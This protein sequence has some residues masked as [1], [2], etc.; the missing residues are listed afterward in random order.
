[1]DTQELAAVILSQTA[2][3]NPIKYANI[4]RATKADE[5]GQIRELLPMMKENLDRYEK[6]A[7][8][9]KEFR[10]QVS[11]EGYAKRRKEAKK[12]FDGLDKQQDVVS[13]NSSPIDISVI[14]SSHYEH[15]VNIYSA[16]VQGSEL[17]CSSKMVSLDETLNKWSTQLNGASLELGE[18]RVKALFNSLQ[19]GSED[20]IKGLALEQQINRGAS[21]TFMQGLAILEKIPRL[22]EQ[23]LQ[24]QSRNFEHY[25]ERLRHRHSN[26]MV[27]CKYEG[28]NS[29]TLTD[30]S[31]LIWENLD[32]VGEIESGHSKDELSAYTIHRANAMI[33]AAKNDEIWKWITV[34]GSQLIRWSEISMPTVDSVLRLVIKLKQIIGEPVWKLLSVD[35]KKVHRDFIDVV[36]SLDLSQ[37]T[38]RPPERAFSKTEK[39]ALEHQNKS[40]QKVADLMA[41]GESVQ[42]IVSEVLKLK[43]I[44]RNFF[45]LENSFYVCRIGTG[46]MFTGESPGAIEII[47]GEKPHVNLNNIWGSGFDEVR[48]FISGMDEAKKWSPLFLA[49]SPSK[50]TDKANVLLVGP[51]GCGKCVRGDT[52]I[53]T[54]RG[55]KTILE[56]QPGPV[57][58]DGYHPI[59]VGVRSTIGM[60]QSSHFYDSGIQP[61]IKIE[62]RFGFKIEGTAKHRVIVATDSGP[63]WK[64]LDQIKEG[65]YVAIVREEL[66]AGPNLVDP[67]KAY[68]LG[69]YVG[70]GNGEYNKEG[71]YKSMNITVGDQDWD[72]FNEKVVGL[73]SKHFCEPKVYKYDGQAYSVRAMKL[74]SENKELLADCGRLAANKVTPKYILEGNK[75]S[76]RAYLS[77]LFDSDGSSYGQRIEFGTNSEKLIRQVQLM[78]TSF[79]I[80]SRVSR[81]TEKAW[82]LNIYGDDARSF[83]QK[84][85]FRLPR[86]QAKV[87]ELEVKANHNYDQVPISKDLWK[88][89]KSESGELPRS[90]HKKLWNYS[91][92]KA[93]PSR[94]T[95][96]Q[97]LSLLNPSQK[98]K[99]ITDSLG[100]TQYRWSKIVSVEN[101]GEHPVYDLVVP[102]AESFAANGMMNHNTEVL[103]SL[104][105][106]PDS[107]AIFAVG[108]DFLTCWLG[109]AQKNPKRLFDEAIKLHKSSGRPVYILIDE[110]D[111]I[112]NDDQSTSKI[113]LSLEFQNLMDGVVAYPGISIWGATNHPKRIPTPMLR[114]FAKVM[115]VGEL[116]K[117]DA[118]SILKYYLETFLPVKD[119]KESDY[120]LWVSKLEGATGD[121]IRKGIDELWLDLIRGF[122][123]NYKEHA[124]TILG[125]IHG[126]YGAAFEISDLTNEDRETIKGMI[127][128]TG[129]VVTPD[130]VS[131]YI[132]KILDNFSIQQQ[133]KV[134]KETYK[135]AKL[136]LAR[137]KSGEFGVG[138]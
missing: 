131:K 52:M 16:L 96:A 45:V 8:Q 89:L 18:E 107:I 25:Y 49:T 51:Q 7:K 27:L 127:S 75:E 98:S 29:A 73:I 115:V 36:E 30:V 93:L 137:Q 24:A 37:I 112:L 134:A 38:Q 78:L 91:S 108:S 41:E 125:F 80:I 58:S 77:G 104:S 11:G 92:G 116:S 54:D 122:V 63:D 60:T 47:P 1:M 56:L 69:Y 135:N 113:N 87:S 109:E 2:S 53:F 13:N 33:E 74:S 70:D 100:S 136:L 20:T 114:R 130:M 9:A 123:V 14:I 99:E 81:H 67:D 39:F 65:D 79:G 28:Q 124:E 50:S 4:I 117:E 97:L 46:N 138:F 121:V 120:D 23:Y 111:M 126:K 19:Q 66:P 95:L 42:D 31:I 85:G 3:D 12:I 34:P 40:I 86:K 82:R 32:K 68:V 57:D 118:K 106:D 105:S 133:I 129:T 5:I 17:L 84:I 22:Y 55:L 21:A 83:Y 6:I 110:I 72:Y 128:E 15:I 44:E 90:T 119:L 132:D 35:L 64:R 71:L 10:K 101:T 94:E 61:C 43:V 59:K 88:I 103:R 48:T 26:G 62:D 102:G 76:W